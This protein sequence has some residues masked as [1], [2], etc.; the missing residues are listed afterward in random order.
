ML[1]D[2]YKRENAKKAGSIHATYLVSGVRQAVE[3]PST[4]PSQNGTSGNMD[5][6]SDVPP[7]SPPMS[8][9]M[10]AASQDNGGCVENVSVLTVTLVREEE[11]AG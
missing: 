9:S 4:S 5:V 3:M 2:F 7:S 10:P 6:D 8:S 1:F 11:L